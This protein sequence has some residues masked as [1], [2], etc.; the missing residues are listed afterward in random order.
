MFDSAIR[1]FSEHLDT[2]RDFTNL[3][4][5]FLARKH[6]EQAQ[7]SAKDLLPLALAFHRMNPEKF[8]LPDGLSEEDLSIAEASL[9]LRV[10]SPDTNQTQG[11]H[12]GFRDQD[13]A[14]AFHQAIRAVHRR[15]SQ[16]KHLHNTSLITLASTTEWF[17]SQVLHAYFDRFPDAVE[18]K[19][20]A[21]SLEDLK[22]FDS[23][24]QARSYLVDCYVEQVLR[25]S[26]EDWL[27]FLRQ[28]IK[29]HMGYIEPHV[30]E[31][32]EI[33]QR[34]N[35]IV[36]NGGVVNNIYMAKVPPCLR[37]GVQCG[38]SLEVSRSYLD[39][40][41]SL[42]ERCYVLVAAE[43]WKKIDRDDPDRGAAL[44]EVAYAHLLAER[45][46][47]AEGLSCFTMNDA[48]L[49]ERDRLIGTVNYWQSLKWQGRL[50][51]ARSDVELADFSAKEQVFQLAQFA[52]LDNVD[53][54]FELLPHALETGSLP[55]GALTEWP[56]FRHMRLEDLCA[57][58]LA[59]EAV[60]PAEGSPSIRKP[61]GA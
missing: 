36:H 5:P 34:R 28:R 26:F 3:A 16:L 51:E 4:G 14:K 22:S 19:E 50:D 55:K 43:L 29:L 8:P 25:G 61:G 30:Q 59:E 17:L 38:D 7:K 13:Q 48:G 58:F 52:L 21:F 46:P 32:S 9:E 24:D 31:L 6:R 12:I 54:F 23:I 15:Q 45:W 18:G 11:V 49:P 10:D 56:L 37:E 44:I 47:V 57:P 41:I 20:K 53:A 35:L 27:A 1:Q 42:F 33:F 39:A 40:A 2:L 60:S